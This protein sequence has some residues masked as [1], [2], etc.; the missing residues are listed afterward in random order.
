MPLQTSF[1]RTA[2]TSLS[3]ALS[4]TREMERIQQ[5][6]DRQLGAST[7]VDIAQAVTVD[8][9]LEE[10]WH[11]LLDFQRVGPCLP[12]AEDIKRIG[13]DAYAGAMRIKLGAVQVRLAGQVRILESDEENRIA[14]LHLEANDRRVRGSVRATTTMR[15][16]A[17]DEFHTEMTVN[18]DAA[19]LGK[20]GQFGQAVLRKKA[21][22]LLSEF[23]QNLSSVLSGNDKQP[24]TVGS[25]TDAPEEEEPGLADPESFSRSAPVAMAPT[26]AADPIANIAR[27]PTGAVIEPALNP[28]PGHLAVS[29]WLA[30]GLM[31]VGLCV[32]LV[33]AL[34]HNIGWEIFGLSIV[35][36]GAAVS[37]APQRGAGR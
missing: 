9:R 22:Q 24:M 6:F 8:A 4:I 23:T 36:S 29:R 1:P 35:I 28:D 14:R 27:G 15:L 30:A 37:L 5:I 12:G 2:L 18:T 34:T 11:F 16:R 26:V 3:L 13:L 21:D 19:V 31:T 7:P 33:A 32:G 20:L 25:R 17:I 10:A